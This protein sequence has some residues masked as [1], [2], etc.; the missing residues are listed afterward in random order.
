MKRAILVPPILSGAPLTELK[1]W[2]GIRLSE[3][4]TSLL[5]LLGAALE[6][7]EAFIGRLPLEAECEEMLAACSGWQKLASLPVQS[8]TALDEVATDGQRSAIDPARYEFDLDADGG[9]RV[10]IG[11]LDADRVAVRFTA[12][13][14]PDWATLPEGLRH[15]ILRLAAHHYRQRDRDPAEQVPPAAVVALWQPWRRMRLA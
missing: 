13:I 2:L 14:A 12:G 10:R 1:A 4:E 15:G 8:I 3:E 5:G 9:A 11:N 7:C 6:S